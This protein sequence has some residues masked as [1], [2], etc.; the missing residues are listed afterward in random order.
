MRAI[1]AIGQDDD[2]L[3][4]RVAVLR[5]AK[6]E[7]TSARAEEAIRLLEQNRFDLL[8]LC[9]TVPPPKVQNIVATAQSLNAKV[10]VLTMA[11]RPNNID[12]ADNLVLDEA[13]TEPARLVA[14]V[15]EILGP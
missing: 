5:H 4:T 1:L 13:P 11:V 8:V 7:V 6:A 12:V 9:H 15:S 10:R 3:N 2:L 14:K